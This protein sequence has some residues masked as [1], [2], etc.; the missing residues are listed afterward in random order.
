HL[1]R[2]SSISTTGATRMPPPTAAVCSVVELVGPWLYVHEA[3]STRLRRIRIG[4]AAKIR[5]N[6]ETRL[7][8]RSG[9][10][11]SSRAAYPSPSP[12]GG[13]GGVAAGGGAAAAASS[14][15]GCPQLG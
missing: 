15:T 9:Y 12:G 1:R 7:S 2:N 8:S 4:I 5:K 3:P 13:S 14:W 6:V 10:S 11:M